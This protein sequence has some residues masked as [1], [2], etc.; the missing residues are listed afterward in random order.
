MNVEDALAIICLIETVAL[1]IL[2]LVVSHL[3]KELH[4]MSAHSQA[5]DAAVAA[6]VAKV[7][8]LAPTLADNAGN[9]ASMDAATAAINGAVTLLGGTP[10]A[11]GSGPT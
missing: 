3:A 9:V 10:A 1:F 11:N 7:N 2:I 5:L 6:L 4:V 8:E